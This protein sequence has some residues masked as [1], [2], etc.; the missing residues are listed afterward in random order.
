MSNGS[1]LN[2]VGTQKWHQRA[3]RDSNGVLHRHRSN[4]CAVF[5]NEIIVGDWQNG[6]LYSLDQSTYTDDGAYLPCIRTSPHIVNDLKRQFFHYF[7]VQF[8]PGVGIATGQGS[9]PEFILRW[10]ND[11][12]FT[13]GNDHTIKIGKAG[14]YKNRAIKRRMGEAREDRKSVV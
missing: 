13:W 4:C 7:Q 2:W 11:G 6:K 1:A 12:G 3:W 8:Q 10:S 14:K 5:N 9:D